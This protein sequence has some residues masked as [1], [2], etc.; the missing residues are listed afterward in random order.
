MITELLA[1]VAA[2]LP[3]GA[4][5][6][7]EYGA[8]DGP[9]L[10][11]SAGPTTARVWERLLAEHPR[12]GLWP[13][14]LDS[15]DPDEEG[16]RPWGGGELSPGRASRPDLY[17]PQRLLARWWESW[18]REEDDPGTT[19]PFGVR[20]P[21]PAPRGVRRESPE[22]AA[23]RCAREV[24]ARRPH[25]RLGLVPAESGAEALAVVGWDGVAEQEDDT[26]TYAAVLASWEDR[27][28]ARLVSA[29][30][31][32]LVVSVAAPPATEGAAL[33]LAAE[34][35]AFC[36]GTLRQGRADTLARHAATLVNS[37]AWTF[38]WD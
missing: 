23:G 5:V 13:L 18:L 36:P 17:D 14:L 29:D 38:W 3:P 31:T 2:L 11:M 7:Q 26:G 20:W 35:V 12:S 28:G 1:D 22:E 34:H 19:A 33:H 32:G 8:G 4:P 30:A 27:F 9:V 21:G 25:C 6:E 16:Y 24:L 15:E 10:W 37:P